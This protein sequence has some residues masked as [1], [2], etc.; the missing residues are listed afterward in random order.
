MAQT[1][2]DA[3]TDCGVVVDTTGL[4]VNGNNTAEI[5][6]ADVF[7]ENFNTCVNM[8]FSELEDNCKTYSRIIVAKGRIRLIP[9]TTVNIRAFFNGQGKK[10]GKM[11]IIA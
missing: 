5:I 4:I 11:N 6:A 8:K 1:I 2:I 3:L 10:S 7:N 9:R